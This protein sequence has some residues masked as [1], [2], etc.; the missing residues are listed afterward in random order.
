MLE[1]NNL[2][3]LNLV[4]S[5]VTSFTFLRKNLKTVN[6]FIFLPFLLFPKIAVPEILLKIYNFPESCEVCAILTSQFSPEIN[7][8]DLAR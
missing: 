4:S 1:M 2:F 3:S 8:S 7:M 5:G 6:V